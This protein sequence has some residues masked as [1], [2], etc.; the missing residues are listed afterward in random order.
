MIKQKIC[1]YCETWESGGIE[2]FLTNVVQRLDMQQF[3]IDIVAASLKD[4]V[5]TRGLEQ[6]GVRFW[7]LSGNTRNVFCN[8]KMF[9]R[10]LEEQHYDVLHLNIYQALSMCYA[11]QA[12]K[13]GIPVRIIH[14]HNT[15]LRKSKMRIVKLAIHA[16]AKQCFAKNGTRFLACSTDAAK[17]MFPQKVMDRK[18]F[19]VVPNGIETTRFCFHQ[20]ARDRFR[21]QWSLQD[22]FVI[23]NI[24]RLCYQKNQSFLLDVFA[25]LKTMRPN[26]K[27]L[28]IGAGEDE[29]RLREKVTQLNIEQDVLFYGTTAMP[30]QVLWAMDVFA[31]P[32]LFEGL[33]I[34]AIEAQAAGL[35]VICSDAIPTEAFVTKQIKMIPLSAGPSEWAKAICNCCGRGNREMSM[36]SIRRAGFDIQDVAKQMAA[37]YSEG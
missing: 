13:I 31:F 18:L 7:E 17:F 23:G 25:R 20:E 15:A 2:S 32:S 3:S 12:K 26:S 19:S 10:I 22:K 24:G 11:H 36:E 16:M 6:I 1:I 8:L 35:P 21:E 37:Y 29:Q 4:S 14:S 33:G 9:R 27:L 30:E 34:V 5:F 28:L